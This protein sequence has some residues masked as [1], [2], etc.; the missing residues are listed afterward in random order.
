MPDYPWFFDEDPQ[1]P[2]KPSSTRPNERGLAII[3]YVQW[4][5]SWLKSYPFYEDYVP[6]EQQMAYPLE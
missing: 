1:H 6:I 3:A 5:G 2:G 4:L